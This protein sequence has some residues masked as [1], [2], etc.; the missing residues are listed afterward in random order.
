MFWASWR[1]EQEFGMKNGHNLY[2]QYPPVLLNEPEQF[3]PCHMR[4]P[5]ESGK[6]RRK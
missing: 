4:Y 2:R 3:E 6:S 1:D 5:C